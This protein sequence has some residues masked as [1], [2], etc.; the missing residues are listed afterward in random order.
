MAAVRGS[1]RVSSRSVV[2]GPRYKGQFL[3]KSLGQHILTDRRVLGKVVRAAHLELEDVVVEVGPGFGVL[4]RELAKRAGQVLA[5]EVDAELVE[6]LRR[7]LSSFHNLHIIHGDI[8]DIPLSQL[9]Q[10]PGRPESISDY[11]VVANLPYQITSP[12]LRYFLESEP[13]PRQMVVM[14]QREVAEAI[15]MAPGH[16]NALSVAIH[17]YGRPQLVAIVPPSS[18]HPPPQVES[19]IL[20]IDVYDEPP[21]SVPSVSTLSKVVRAGF[22]TRRKQLHNALGNG[23][24][25]PGANALALMSQAGI[26]PRR[27][28]QELSLQEWAKLAWALQETSDEE[29][30]GPPMPWPSS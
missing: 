7:D 1:G 18:F 5:V 21:V 11:K 6:V 19:A 12:V 26:P 10:P 28:A 8:L 14:I 20:K 25:I 24:K 15:V 13:R 4:T 22:S 30:L 23:L 2:R 3:K 27:R 16:A 29:A 17:Y 9:L